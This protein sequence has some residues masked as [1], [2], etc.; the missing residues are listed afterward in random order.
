ML[1]KKKH[2]E[3]PIDCLRCNIRTE[4]KEIKFIGPKFEIDICP[5]CK[6]IW[7]DPGELKKMVKDRKISDYLT[8]DIGTKS[9]SK[10]VCPRCGGLMDIEKADDIEVDVCL[11]CR[12]VWLDEGELE[13]LKL[14]SKEGF[15]GDELEK[16]IEKWEDDHYKN[17]IS[18]RNKFFGKFGR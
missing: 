9:E 10:L 4:R 16:Y 6:G 13:D 11:S 12:G 5:K 8:K 14:K 3:K 2:Y 1:K 18:K 17:N 7:L 15:K